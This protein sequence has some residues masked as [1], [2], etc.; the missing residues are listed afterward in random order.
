MLPD[1]AS[2]EQ[3]GGDIE[4]YSKVVDPLTDLPAEA[5]NESRADTAQCTR[6]VGRAYVSFSDAGVVSEHDAVWGKTLAVKPL[7]EVLS[8]GRYQI[9]WPSSV[10]DARNVTRSVNLRVGFPSLTSPG[11]VAAPNKTA[12]NVFVFYVYSMAT[13][14]YANPGGTMSLMVL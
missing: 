3:F 10:V 13:G 14:T 7:V 9:T 4:D 6:M 8:A 1:S 12:P 5:G 2:Y 11:F